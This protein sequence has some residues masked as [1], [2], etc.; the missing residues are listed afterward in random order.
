MCVSVAHSSLILCDPITVD[1]HVSKRA[2]ADVLDEDIPS[3]GVVSYLALS[4][5]VAG[6]WETGTW[7]E[8]GEMGR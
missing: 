7:E 5:I 4:I 1:A 2:L 8:A 3:V 6:V